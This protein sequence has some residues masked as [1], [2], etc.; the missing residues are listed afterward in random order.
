MRWETLP[1]DTAVI[2]QT[3]ELWEPGQGQGQ[4]GQKTEGM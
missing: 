2:V 3:K 1:G 4:W